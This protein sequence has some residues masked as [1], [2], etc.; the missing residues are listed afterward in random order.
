MRVKK[1]S[2]Y[3][4]ISTS[5]VTVHGHII[6]LPCSLVETASVQ[7]DNYPGIGEATINLFE[8]SH[9]LKLGLGHLQAHRLAQSQRAKGERIFSN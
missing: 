8:L 5:H 6:W 9:V 3:M 4:Y 1:A 2:I 7:P